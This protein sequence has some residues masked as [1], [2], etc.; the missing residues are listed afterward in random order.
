[1]FF[2]MMLFMLLI[3]AVEGDSHWIITSGLFGIASSIE[4]FFYKYFNNK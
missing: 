4:H 3:G 2:F 1:M